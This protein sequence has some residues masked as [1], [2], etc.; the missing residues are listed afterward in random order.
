MRQPFDVMRDCRAK[1]G[2]T[3]T[4]R[5]GVLPPLV[6]LSNPEHV[7]DV[8]AGNGDDTHAG[9]LATSLAPFLGEKSLILLDGPEHRRMRRLMMPPFHG[10]RMEAYGAQIVE[11]THEAV[12]RWRAGT[13]FPVH[14]PMQSVTLEVILRTVFG[15]DD[16]VARD[17][18]RDAL[19]RVLELATWPPLLLPFMQR[20]LGPWSPWGKY[21]RHAD[22]ANTQ[23]GDLIERRRREG[24]EGRADILSMF[25][26]VRD[27]Q[28][29][30]LSPQELR[31]ELVTLLV[32]GHETTAT[33]L[34][35]AL[36]W[37][38]T[39]PAVQKRLRA[40]LHDAGDLDPARIAKLDYLDAVVRETLRINPI[41]PLV[42]RRLKKPM[43]FA[44]YDLPEGVG[45]AP[46]VYLVHHNPLVYDRPERFDPERFLTRRY[47]AH[48]WLPFGGGI[49]RCIGMAF[50]LY[51]MKM[52][53]ATV[54]SR[55]WMHLPAPER[56]RAVRRSITMC[57]SEGLPVTVDVVLPRRK[58]GRPSLAP[59]AAG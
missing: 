33:S 35:W 27:E 31:D 42:G 38:L 59:A 52:V 24:V 20:D 44:G 48:E 3:F 50:A 43:R 8:F 13:T 23:L 22:A 10:E 2:E 16:L 46:S 57:P 9:E 41:I 18:M 47:G 40:E 14:G 21:L 39:E 55:A 19:T 54:L 58:A 4:M 34:A 32:A 25:L 6:L 36:R 1:Y 29:E 5:L 49:R 51:E 53:L 15:L 7:K 26:G 37:I 11:I 28:G 45:I 30:S 17:R 56:V 12:D